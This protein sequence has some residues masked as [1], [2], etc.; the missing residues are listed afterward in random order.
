M[1]YIG[2]D[3]GTTAVK[4]IVCD[5]SGKIIS[6]GQKIY[7]LK[8]GKNGSVTQRAKDWWNCSVEAIKEACTGVDKNEIA[9][10]GLSAQ[11]A[12]MTA[13]DEN[14]EDLI[15]AITWMD[16]TSF[17]ESS[18]LDNI[19]GAEKIYK[20]CGWQNT[21]TGDAAKIRRIIKRMPEVSKRARIY[22]STMAYVNIHLTGR[23]VT[24]PTS[25]AIR[26]LYNI[27]K[28][29]WDEEI[30]D[31]VGI[32]RE[33]L[34]EVLPAGEYIGNLTRTAAEQ[35][36]LNEKVKVFNGSHD[37]YCSAVGSGTLNVGDVML[38]T[39]TAWVILCIADKLLYTSSYLAPGISPSGNFGAMAAQMSA[40]SVMRRFTEI[41]GDN[42]KNL[43]EVAKD[44]MESAKNLI[45]LPFC[46]GAGFPHRAPD[47]DGSIFGI[48][49]NHDRYDIA[50][51]L[52]EGAAFETRLA[53]EEFSSYGLNTST[54]IMSGG[55]AR[56]KL[57]S[58][59]VHSVLGCRMFVSG[60]TESCAL[61]AAMMAAV[62]MGE[63]NNLFEAADLFVKREE[64]IPPTQYEKDFYN[65]K[66]LK[67]IDKINLLYGT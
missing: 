18:E 19:I 31:A 16:T 59:I 13:L 38:A 26:I 50:R 21:S 64:L 15:D 58:H 29:D 49:L 17:E 41:F 53:L 23:A 3:I 20:K 46:A 62:G 45:F 43:D 6:H 44:R 24:D 52:M 7:E 67:Y 27:E 54:V 47:A 10:I 25:A 28:Q 9:A 33:K 34:P 51:A 66:Y 12:S 60:E 8:T 14:G 36:G 42:Y 55:A 65:E 11:G 30:L 4:A 35:L 22:P 61:G 57:W 40:G 39:G 63:F 1:Y 37:Q 5:G 32:G 56:S 48:K 2:L